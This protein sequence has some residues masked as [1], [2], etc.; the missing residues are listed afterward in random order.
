MRIDLTTNLTLTHSTN[1]QKSFRLYLAQEGFSI[2][3]PVIINYTGTSV[4]LPSASF[5]LKA[6]DIRSSAGNLQLFCYSD[7]GT[8]GALNTL[9]PS[10]GGIHITLDNTD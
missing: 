7:S 1:E 5:L 3:I 6:T 8:Q 4:Y 2:G 9:M 10:S